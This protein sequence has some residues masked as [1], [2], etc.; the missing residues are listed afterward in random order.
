M[1]TRADT[2]ENVSAGV[3]DSAGDESGSVADSSGSDNAAD[4][5]D[6]TQTDSDSADGAVAD[7]LPD[8]IEVPT[9]FDQWSVVGGIDSVSGVGFAVSVY[10]EEDLV[11]TGATLNA[12]LD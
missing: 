6:T 1:E 5:T 4:A 9:E 12:T 8:R 7:A 10:M 2:D 3:V 11:Y